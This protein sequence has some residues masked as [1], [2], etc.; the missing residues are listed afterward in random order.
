MACKKYLE[1]RGIQSSSLSCPFCNLDIETI[2]HI[3]FL[4]PCTEEFWSLCSLWLD[5]STLLPS[6]PELHFLKHWGS[7][8][9]YRTGQVRMVIWASI[10]WNIWKERN[11]CF[12]KEKK[13]RKTKVDT[14][15]HVFCL[16]LVDKSHGCW[17]WDLHLMA[18]ETFK[19]MWKQILWYNQTHKL[20]F[21]V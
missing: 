15:Y 7:H 2:E 4:C 6:S 10:T 16:I 9:S 8:T 11:F 19:P 5:E 20:Q 18:I 13:F 17:G 12:F 21:R 3:F 14:R 1:K